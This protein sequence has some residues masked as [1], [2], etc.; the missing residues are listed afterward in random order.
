MTKLMFC[1]QNNNLFPKREEQHNLHLRLLCMM[2]HR[3]DNTGQS[4]SDVLP[5]WSKMKYLRMLTIFTRPK[6]P[7]VASTDVCRE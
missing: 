7:D 4:F 3:L 5:A 2:K 6:Q 1:I